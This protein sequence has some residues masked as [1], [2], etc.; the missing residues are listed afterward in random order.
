MHECQTL[1]IHWQT[2]LGKEGKAIKRGPHVVHLPW[3][4]QMLGTHLV[5]SLFIIPNPY[6]P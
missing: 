4:S 6:L 2:G 1:T 3:T 5:P